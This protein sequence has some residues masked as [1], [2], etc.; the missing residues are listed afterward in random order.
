MTRFLEDHRSLVLAGFAIAVALDNL[1]VVRDLIALSNTDRTASHIV[2]VPFVT[3]AL[4]WR[5]RAN[6]VPAARIDWFAGVPIV[7]T[8]LAL[9]AAVRLTDQGLTVK[10]SGLVLSWIGGF[11]VLYGRRASRDALFP[12]LFLCL[13]IPAPGRVITVAVQF[14]K[15]GS[16]EAV[17]NLFTLLRIPFNRDG[18]V[19][20]LP[21][22]TIEI[23]DDCSGI[24]SSI[25]LMLTG[26]IAGHLML[27]TAWKKI[28]LIAVILPIAIL[29][30][31]IRIVGL[32]LL[33]IYVNPAFL[34]GRLHRDGGIVFFLLGL[35]LLGPILVALQRSEEV[36]QGHASIPVR[37]S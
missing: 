23:A 34:D 6:L 22:V 19:F 8:G 31:G 21:G 12:L 37:S 16:A 9:L 5:M 26:L 1:P 32:S 35:L 2:L 13:T 29:K 24:R 33:G 14:L 3:V 27:S 18:F 17:T 10:A 25:A 36:V 11:V 15:I 20:A 30:N 7:L 28:V 4:L